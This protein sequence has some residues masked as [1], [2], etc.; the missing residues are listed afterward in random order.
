MYDE[1][2]LPECQTIII[3][4]PKEGE[5][6]EPTVLRKNKMDLKTKVYHRRGKIHLKSASPA[7][8]EQPP[9][10]KVKAVQALQLQHKTNA[11]K[12][13]AIDIRRRNG[14]LVD[15]LQLMASLPEKSEN[16]ARVTRSHNNT[17][18]MVNKFTTTSTT[19]N[20][21]NI[22]VVR[23]SQSKSSSSPITTT[24]IITKTFSPSKTTHSKTGVITLKSS[25]PTKLSN[26]PNTQPN[27][28]Q[29]QRI[30][31]VSK[32]NKSDTSPLDTRIL[33]IG[34]L[35]NNVDMDDNDQ[36]KVLT[37]CTNNRRGSSHQRIQLTTATS[38]SSSSTVN[39]S[40]TFNNTISQARMNPKR[41]IATVTNKSVYEN[42]AKRCASTSANNGDMS[43]NINT[44]GLSR[45]RLSTT[46]V[47]SLLC[48]QS[49][50]LELNANSP[51]LSSPL[52]MLSASIIK[53]LSPN[54]CHGTPRVL[55]DGKTDSSC[56]SPK[57]SS[58]ALDTS[59]KIKGNSPPSDDLTSLSWL[60]SLDMV[61]MVPHLTTP[62]TP[63]ASP[64][65]GS[66]N[67]SSKDGK[68]K[69][70]SQD[71]A[72]E[73]IRPDPV[74]YSKD[75]SVKPPFSYASLICM[76]MKEN[77][78]KMTLS[79]IY[80]WIREHYIYYKTADPSWQVSR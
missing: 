64:P 48:S 6:L 47:R 52:D 34:P 25:T 22:T 55:S 74:D 27:D 17:A 15:R 4:H 41:N 60:H 23:N 43:S 51:E 66:S 9:V 8:L 26:T 38:L 65:L 62:P 10:I 76:A 5:F 56:A 7:K 77:G 54:M 36:E 13:D 16:V 61:G 70:K 19:Q 72:E 50:R 12:I 49:S 67:N 21:N 14:I 69:G 18:S 45:E 46:E 68:K 80:E 33:E 57:S 58:P 20:K 63:P 79:A 59:K 44:D 11:K 73:V 42:P 2:H 78:N 24:T 28:I 30:S 75:G 39:F 31:L 37:K 40:Q 3:Q 1:K 35:L 53:P 32:T 29:S 71:V